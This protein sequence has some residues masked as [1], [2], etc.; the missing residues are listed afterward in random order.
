MK[1]TALLTKAFLLPEGLGGGGGPGLW[2]H[3]RQATGC[4]AT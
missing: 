4:A 3:G 2:P 1:L